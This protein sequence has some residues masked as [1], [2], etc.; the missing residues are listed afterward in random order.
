MCYYQ[1]EEDSSNVLVYTMGQW[2]SN[3]VLVD[4]NERA[5]FFFP[6]LS[7]SIVNFLKGKKIDLA[8]KT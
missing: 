2:P 7:H 8:L 5:M 6:I 1:D 3:W 4:K